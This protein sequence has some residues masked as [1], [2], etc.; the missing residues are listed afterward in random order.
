M[1]L[2]LLAGVIFLALL[3][4]VAVWLGE[5]Q[6]ILVRHLLERVVV[7][8]L[9]I[10]LAFFLFRYLIANSAN[11]HLDCVNVNLM[12]RDLRA[13]DL[14][15]GN[16]VEANLRGADLTNADLREADLSGA[17]LTGANLENAKLEGAKL[18]GTNLTQAYVRGADLRNASLNGADFI[19]ADLTGVSLTETLLQGA[20]FEK[21]KLI[22]VQLQNTNIAGVVFTGANLQG[23]DLTGA[24]LQGARLSQA[25]LSGSFLVG[26]D[27]SGAWLN[28][29]TLTGADLTGANLSGAAMMGAN[30]SSTKLE[31]A[32]LFG[33]VLVGAQM[34]GVLLYGADLTGARLFRAELTINDLWLD[35]VIQGLNQLQQSNI[36]AD[37]ALAGVQFDAQTVWPTGNE[38]LLSDMLGRQYRQQVDDMLVFDEEMP[39]S[40][41]ADFVMAG[42]FTVMPLS[43]AIYERFTEQENAQRGIAVRAKLSSMG[44]GTG[45]DYFCQTGESDIA[46]ASRPIRPEEVSHCAAINRT[47]ISIPVGIDA[48]AVVVNADNG[49]AQDLTV[50][51][52]NRMF[53]AEYWFD[54]NL[55]WP[56]EPILRFIPDQTSGTFD[57]FVEQIFGGNAQTLLNA[58]HTGTSTNINEIVYNIITNPFATGFMGF[59]SYQQN[60]EALNLLA[61]NGVTPNAVTVENGEYPL[62]R[63][64]LL[65]TDATLL[66]ENDAL[67]QFLLFYLDHV[68]EVIDQ[69]GYFP[70]PP[71]ALERSQTRLHELLSE[72]NLQNN[73]STAK[74]TWR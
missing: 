11:C 39:P 62:T 47:P 27:L 1:L 17:D 65:Y 66:R 50:Q 12:G 70:L 37:V 67:A 41:Q 22:E 9:A 36:R 8:V 74:P 33:A 40:E 6:A 71:E 4:I 24:Q 57:F 14:H 63:P 5:T 32:K 73:D 56:R 46:M 45:F 48:I 28:L 10:L 49:F 15:G 43:Q 2:P 38:T 7:I 42:S 35:P 44:T 13:A 23:A 54:A 16:F 55:E 68:N 20:G 3:I 61:V 59:A 25:D 53:T 18:I 21:A 64:L 72:G 29:A 34:Q 19:E 31:R 51:D 26:A 30:L 69:V 60:A 58:P 52:L